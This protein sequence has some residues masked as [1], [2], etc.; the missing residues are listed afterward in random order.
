MGSL[1]HLLD[2]QHHPKPFPGCLPI[3]YKQVYQNFHFCQA[4]I[5]RLKVTFVVKV[6]VEEARVTMQVFLEKADP[7]GFIDISGVN[8]TGKSA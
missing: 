3:T 5:W 4:D 2:D 6:L 7:K 8:F 1:L